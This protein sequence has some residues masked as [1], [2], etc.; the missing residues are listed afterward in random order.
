MLKQM[1]IW[2]VSVALHSRSRK[3]DLTYNGFN[4]D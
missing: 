3:I 2:N 1:Q 4:D